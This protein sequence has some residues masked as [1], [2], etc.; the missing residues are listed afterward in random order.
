MLAMPSDGDAV[1]R[2]YDP[3]RWRKASMV[4]VFCAAVSAVAL[5][6]GL[7]TRTVLKRHHGSSSGGMSGTAS[8]STSL[9]Y[10]GASC[11]G[12]NPSGGGGALP[13]WWTNTS[14]IS[15]TGGAPTPPPRACDLDAVTC[16]HAA[17]FTTGG[18]IHIATLVIAVATTGL[19]YLEL[20][21]K[22]PASLQSWAITA[23]VALLNIATTVQSA[24]VARGR[25]AADNCA[26]TL[27]E[28]SPGVCWYAAWAA[29]AILFFGGVCYIASRHCNCCCATRHSAVMLTP[30]PMAVH[31][32]PIMQPVPG[33]QP[34]FPHHQQPM[35]GVPQPHGSDAY[36]GAP[37][38]YPGVVMGTPSSPMGGGGV[39]GA[40]VSQEMMAYPPPPP[41]PSSHRGGN[42]LPGPPRRRRSR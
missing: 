18:V 31:A 3:Q 37:P 39:Y 7:A 21:A 10:W 28:F 12:G 24:L 2:P 32:Q 20:Q 15:P 36:S 13:W 6:V 34:G 38:Q 14:S 19:V 42:P 8:G 17:F 35:L 30:V 9:T 29:E 4:L 41:P 1:P 16:D 40:P 33:Y 11:E 23:C 5:A 25:R 27:D 22:L 26:P